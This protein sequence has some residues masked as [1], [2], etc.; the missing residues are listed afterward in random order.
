MDEII[1][2]IHKELKKNID[3]AYKQTESRLFKEGRNC[4]GVRTGIV[5]GIGKKFLKQLKNKSKNDIFA[6][7]EELLSSGLHEPRTIAFQW[8]NQLRGEFS[9]EEFSIFELWLEKY[10]HDWSGC[11]DLCCG[12]LGELI[13]QYPLLIQKITQWTTSANKWL[14]R[15]AAVSLI[16]SVRKR[17]CLKEIFLVADKLLLDKE[18]LVQKG[19]GWMLKEASTQWP[20]EV[21][22]Y[23]MLQ[24]GIMSR[25]ALRYAIEKMPLMWRKK[26]MES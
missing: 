25:T 3:I 8:A 2:Q 1:K 18:D 17:N 9:L 24:K 14:R 4:Y 22:R 5:R 13:V 10:V 15:A 19:Y 7:C 6:L 20:R 21:F 12:A 23:T 16:P 11:D 26:V